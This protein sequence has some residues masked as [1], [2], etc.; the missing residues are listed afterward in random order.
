VR[1]ELPFLEDENGVLKS[2]SLRGPWPGRVVSCWI[3]F[4]N[5]LGRLFVT[6]ISAYQLLLSEF[7]NSRQEGYTAWGGRGSV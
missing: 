4:K 3:E 5:R 2:E 6:E 1:S 7:V